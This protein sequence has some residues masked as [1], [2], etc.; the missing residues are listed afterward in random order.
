MKWRARETFDFLTEL[1]ILKENSIILN[2]FGIL[3]KNILIMNI[4]LY[5]NILIFLHFSLI[6]EL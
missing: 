3:T 1:N 6:N 2:I 4:I 5:N